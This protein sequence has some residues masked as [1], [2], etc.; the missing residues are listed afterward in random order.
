MAAERIV[1]AAPRPASLVDPATT[2]PQF[3]VTGEDKL[4]LEINNAVAGV[5]VVLTGR[6]LDPLSGTIKPLRADVTPLSTGA[7][8][9]IIIALN[10]CTLL[11]LVVRAI[12]AHVEAGQCFVQLQVVRGGE[13]SLDVI[14][15][16]LSGY[17]GSGFGLGWPGT[18]LAAPH[19]GPGWVNAQRDAAIPAGFDPSF[20][21]PSSARW[22]IRQAGGLLTTSGVAGTRTP[23]FRMLQQSGFLWSAPTGTPQPPG[24][25]MLH[26]WG[27]GL[28]GSADPMA[29]V[30]LGPIPTGAMLTT[31][32]SG[33]ASVS[34]LT[35]GLQATDQWQYFAV[36]VE[37]WRNPVI[38]T[39]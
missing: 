17:I 5:R 4:R 1:R 31:T 16:L 7:V 11:N 22:R 38:N 24:T 27:G 21:M 33:G 25:T 13:T 30:G 26:G 8:S 19:Q 9:T 39:A 35:Q 12:D 23:Y 18:P 10:A 28:S 14:G 36:L 15:V 34:V 32:G 37:E 3:V 2:S 29:L 6:Y 20:T